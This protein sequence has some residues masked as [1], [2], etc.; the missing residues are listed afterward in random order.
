MPRDVRHTA[1]G[2]I[3]IDPALKPGETPPAP[4][5]IAWP[6]HENG[7]LKV[8]SICACGIS[9]TFPFCDGAH[10]VCKNEEA[11]HVYRYDIPTRTVVAKE[12][13]PE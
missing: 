13:I 5:V 2:N 7:E 9:A 8:V 10:K 12:Q 1:T 3:K 6:R 11:G 4:N